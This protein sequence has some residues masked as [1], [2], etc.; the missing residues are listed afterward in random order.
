[1][2]RN[3][4][5][6]VLSVVSVMSLVFLAATIQAQIISYDGFSYPAGN[7]LWGTV[8]GDGDGG[9]TWGSTWSSTSAALTTNNSSGLSYGALPVLGGGTVLGNPSGSTGSAAQSQRMLPGTLTSLVGGSG[10]IWVGFLY[11]NWGADQAGLAGFRETGLRLISGATL[12]GNGSAN[13]T[14]TDRLD[15]GT[16][17]TYVAGAS[18]KLSLFSG[19]TFVASSLTTPRGPS[20]G[21]TVFVL[22]RLDF[23]NTTAADTAYAWFNP[24]LASEPGTGSAISFTTADLTSIN[25]LRFQ[26][27]GLNASGTNAVWE[28]DELRVGYTWADM[29]SA[30]PEPGALLISGL[31]GLGI[32]LARK[33]RK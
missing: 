28:L 30:V 7:R 24:S 22:V 19:S 26:A 14:G 12:N 29:V 13:V 20:A 8:P 32:L 27:G 18:D 5:L 25:A 16:P 4:S 31:A 33:F 3:L 11:Q 6:R 10:T 9:G 1:M 2:Q 21:N 23:D 15:V 17:N